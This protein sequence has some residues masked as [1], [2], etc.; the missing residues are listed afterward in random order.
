[1][2]CPTNVHWQTVKRILRYLHGIVSHG[3]SI[4]ASSD[5]SLTCYTDADWASCLDDRRGTSGYCTLLGSS[6][7]S[8]S[9]FKQKVV[10]R[11]SSKFEYR[12]LANAA[13]ELTWVESLLHELQIP[14]SPPPLLFCDNISACY[15]IVNPILHSWTKHV[16]I[17][18]HFVHEKVSNGSLAVHFTPFESQLV[19]IM[20]KALPTQRFL[21]LHSKLM[22]LPRPVILRG[23]VRTNNVLL[24]GV[25]L[26]DILT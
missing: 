7:I 19:D 2:H 23:D 21:A 18:Y 3:L 24:S 5:L 4:A 13:T 9:S 10:S 22:V 15:L 1:M 14:F 11:S 26:Y 20:T 8:W 12:G 25:Q 17:D 16:E 6:L